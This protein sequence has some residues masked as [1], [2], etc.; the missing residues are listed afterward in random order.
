MPVIYA[1]LKKKLR[2][3][4]AS[5]CLRTKVLEV[6]RLCAQGQAEEFTSK[7]T[8]V[9]VY[10][11]VFSPLSCGRPGVEASKNLANLDVTQHTIAAFAG[12]QVGT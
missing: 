1:E 12:H 4:L 3:V 9:S 8:A 11:A 5:W 7:F 10:Q 2:G 6:W